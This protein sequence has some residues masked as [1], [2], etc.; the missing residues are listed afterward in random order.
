SA[1]KRGNRSGTISYQAAS[2]FYRGVF[3]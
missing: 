3:S 1:E 2:T